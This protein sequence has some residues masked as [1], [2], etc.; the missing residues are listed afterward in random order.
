MNRRELLK[1]AS[2]GVA[3]TLAGV[4]L[5]ESVKKQKTIASF[6]RHG[7]DRYRWNS[8]AK[9]W[10]LQP[11]KPP[12]FRGDNHMT[13]KIVCDGTTWEWFDSLDRWILLGV[14]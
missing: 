2:A 8:E 5:R 4:K 14:D 11:Y 1:L 12:N 10:E 13:V 9:D 7:D 6:T 3:G